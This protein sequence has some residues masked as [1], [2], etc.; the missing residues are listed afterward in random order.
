M[1]GEIA[2]LGLGAMGLPMAKVLIKK[3][4][5]LTVLKHRNK[6][7]IELLK[8]EGVRVA[9]DIHDLFSVASIIASILPSDEELEKLFLNDKY[10]SSIPKNA[11]LVD[12]TTAA[13]QTIIKIERFLKKYGV[14][15]VDAPVSGGVNRATDGTLSFF[16]GASD[17]NFL[18]AHPLLSA[19]GT[20]IFRLGEVG[21]GKAMKAI[22]QM[23]AA[24][25]TVLTADALHMIEK[26][27]LAPGTAYE[28]LCSSSG[29]STMLKNKY[30]KMQER[31]YTANFTAKLML[32]DLEIAKSIAN[33]HFSATNKAVYNRFFNLNEDSLTKDIA[34][35]F[36]NDENK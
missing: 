1:Q 5:H 29:N 11:V 33:D 35:V 4:F 18:K 10:A 14:G 16:C 30:S 26:L 7:P 15:V 20:S 31:D 3:G 8:K 36:K 27:G 32:K 22:N 28:A 24:A 17:D 25:H 6:E 23:L 19:L 34:I 12:M 2:F 9:T 21:N 13:P